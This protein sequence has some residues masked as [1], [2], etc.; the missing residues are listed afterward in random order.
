MFEKNNENVIEQLN[1]QIT[2]EK[3]LFLKSWLVSKNTQTYL[4]LE[5][6]TNLKLKLIWLK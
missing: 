5:Q 2:Y 1:E 6:S 4:I 3:K